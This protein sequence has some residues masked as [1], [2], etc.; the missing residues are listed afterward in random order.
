[1]KHFV[2]IFL[3]VN[4]RSLQA[5]F[6]SLTLVLMGGGVES[7]PAIFICENNRKSNKIMHSVDFLMVVLKIWAFFTYFNVVVM[8]GALY[9]SITNR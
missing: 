6:F 7:I 1:M 8:G 4:L 2:N 5:V 3:L 9:L